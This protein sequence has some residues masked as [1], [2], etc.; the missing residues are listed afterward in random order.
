M[1]RAQRP[2]LTAEWRYLAMLNFPVDPAV[3]RPL[4]PAGTELDTWRGQALVSVVGF[5]FLNTRLLG[6]PVPWHRNFDEVNLRFYVRREAAGELRRGVTFIREIVPR[7]AIAALAR[8]AYNEPYLH[9][10]MRHLVPESPPPGDAGSVEYGWRHAGAW[11]SLRLRSS[12]PP[13]TLEPG[14]EEQ[15]I[16][17]HYWGYTRQRDGATIEYPVRHPSW[18]VWQAVDAHLDCDASKL[19]GPGFVEA[20]AAPPC[21]AFLAEGSAVEVGFPRRIA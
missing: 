12:G 14:S 1:N 4:V 3:L 13:E 5:R 18:R 10:P 7:R 21:S 16:T 20:L 6:V 17:E 15:F 11:N 8:F 2:F 19:Y 9:R